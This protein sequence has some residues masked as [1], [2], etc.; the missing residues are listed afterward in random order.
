MIS[1]IRRFFACE[2]E[3]RRVSS[4]L[5]L[6]Q[7]SETATVLIVKTCRPYQWA[8]W[9]RGCYR[10]T[11]GSVRSPTSC[12]A[13]IEPARRPLV[14]DIGSAYHEIRPFVIPLK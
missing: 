11:D 9:L 1:A 2:T 4:S 10:A 8:P 13:S 5:V 7:T 6:Q 12:D 3:G 14:L